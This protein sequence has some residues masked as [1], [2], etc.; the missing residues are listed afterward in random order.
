M[1]EKV[2][3]TAGKAWKVLGEKGPV[4]PKALS[5]SLK[6]QEDVVLQAIGWLAREDKIRYE[7]RRNRTLV[8]LV[9]S[10]MES[11]RRLFGGT[12]AASAGPRRPRRRGLRLF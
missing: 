8:S 7:T 1:K 3:E 2:I 11:F 6:E 5:R 10:E 9:E 12:P 4:T